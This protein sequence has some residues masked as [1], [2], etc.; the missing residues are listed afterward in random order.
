MYVNKRIPD[1]QSLAPEAKVL[2]CFHREHGMHI[3]RQQKELVSLESSDSLK[4][5]E[6]V[7]IPIV[8][9]D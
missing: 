9:I 1:V 7:I 6:V 8:E 4:H 3:S 2:F 5:L